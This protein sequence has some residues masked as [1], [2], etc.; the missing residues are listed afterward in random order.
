MTVVGAVFPAL[1]QVGLNRTG[2]RYPGPESGFH[3][4]TFTWD[5][6]T[7]EHDRRYRRARTSTHSSGKRIRHCISTTSHRPHSQIT[8]QPQPCVSRHARSARPARDARSRF[9]QPSSPARARLDVDT[10]RETRQR[11][12]ADL[13][14]R[15]EISLRPHDKLVNDQCAALII[16]STAVMGPGTTG[17]DRRD[18]QHPG[19]FWVAV[20]RYGTCG[21]PLLLCHP[22]V[23]M[24]WSCR[25]CSHRPH[26]S[27]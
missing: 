27:R 16:D 11:G 1:D 2:V 18:L 20:C 25:I 19:R 21:N 14:R 13:K 3:G 23:Q 22:S 17:R 6:C 5:L 26:A 4:R 12:R 24:S 7:E 10:T 8:R 15:H 9:C